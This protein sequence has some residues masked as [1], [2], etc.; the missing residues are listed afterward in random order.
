MSSCG[1]KKNTPVNESKQ[2]CSGQKEN[3]DLKEQS[4]RGDTGNGTTETGREGSSD[5]RGNE[6]IKEKGH[7]EPK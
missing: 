5:D 1:R 3:Q 6:G 4:I 2:K 7:W